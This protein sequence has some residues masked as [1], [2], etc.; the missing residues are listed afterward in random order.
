MVETITPAGC[1]SRR[2]YRIALALFSAAAVLASAALGALLGLAGSALDRT[3]ALSVVAVLALV[4]AA[5][6]MG[7][8]PGP[9][10][11]ARGQVPERW[12]RD[13]PLPAWSLA[14][15]AGLGVGL[16][17]R[18]PVT[19]F[20]VACAGALALGD[21]LVAAACLAPFGAGRALMVILPTVRAADPAAAV[22]RL[23]SRSRLV[24]PVNAAALVVVAVLVGASPALS[25]A[26][27]VRGGFDPAAWGEVV[28]EARVDPL[29]GPSVQV[30]PPGAPPIGFAGGRSPALQGDLLAFADAA[31]IRVVRWTT[32]EQIARLDGPYDAPAIEWPLVAFRAV[33]PATAAEFIEVA[34][35]TTGERRGIAGARPNADLGRPALR[36]G[37]IAW[38]IATG[39]RSQIR[40]RPVAAGPQ[41]SKVIASS[42]S[43]LLVNPSLARG[44]VLWV[45]QIGPISHLRLR[46]V[47]RGGVRTLA[48]LRGP[49]EI[50]WTTALGDTQAY[51]TRWNP[52]TGR[53]RVVR[54]SWRSPAAPMG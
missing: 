49:S 44:R 23:A 20:L 28:A 53:A 1:G 6:E 8:I 31:G 45:E 24:R 11:G 18:L 37:L 47:S 13:W 26:P 54:R 51:A 29:A 12:R 25:Q 15:G 30:R 52:T 21:P 34:D 7:L 43:S 36:G 39:R 9:V 14:Y 40:L 2:R 33:N 3:V 22:G 41:R 19:T 50:L 5:R 17:T 10:P 48:T 27:P 16:L 32:G 4:A 42:R 38:H 46:R 35:L